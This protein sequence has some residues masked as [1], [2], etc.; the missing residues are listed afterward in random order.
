MSTIRVPSI[1]PINFPLEECMSTDERMRF[2]TNQVDVLVR[3]CQGSL[4]ARGYR[5][6]CSPRRL[7]GMLLMLISVSL[8]TRCYVWRAQYL[9]LTNA[10]PPPLFLMGTNSLF[11]PTLPYTCSFLSPLANIDIPGIEN[12]ECA[13]TWMKEVVVGTWR[14]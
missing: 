3:M 14:W 4:S 2:H 7:Q 13:I 11:Y 9:N 5:L 10:F 12:R 8:C 1:S 6:R